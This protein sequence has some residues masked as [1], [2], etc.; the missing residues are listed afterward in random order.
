MTKYRRVLPQDKDLVVALYLEGMSM[1]A[2]SEKTGISKSKVS[3]ILHEAESPDKQIF[4]CHNLRANL[5]VRGIILREYTDLV[6]TKNIFV[7][8]GIEP[9][10][11][12][13][14]IRELTQLCFRMELDFKM[15][16]PHFHNFCQFVYSVPLDPTENLETK[17][18]SELKD[19]Q[20]IVNKLDSVLD[21]HKK[22]IG[23]IDLLEKI[24]NN[25][26]NA[27]GKQ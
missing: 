25:F 16:V 2:I 6:R 22:L 17:L 4:L 27:P 24:S 9:G 23:A 15:L 13:A 1:R 3:D 7:R 14:D 11:V 19:I 18:E 8:A 20:T 26:S 5:N 10:K 12:L 21:R